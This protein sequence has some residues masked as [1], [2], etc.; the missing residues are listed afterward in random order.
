MLSMNSSLSSPDFISLSGCKQTRAGLSGKDPILFDV[1]LI[2]FDSI[3][4]CIVNYLRHSFNAAFTN[5]ESVKCIIHSFI[6]TFQLEF[7][8]N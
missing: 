6:N 2:R 7:T 1:L 3:H 4:R 8:L 5:R